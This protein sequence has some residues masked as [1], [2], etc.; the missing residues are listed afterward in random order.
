[1]KENNILN[2][3]EVRSLIQQ[4]KREELEYIIAEMYKMIPKEKKTDG[5]L[6]ELIKSP[7]KAKTDR[8]KSKAKAK[9]QRPFEEVLAE[10][11]FFVDNA[12]AQNYLVPN[13]TISKKERPKWRF[14]VKR[15]YKELNEYTADE[16]YI[17][18][19]ADALKELYEVMTYSCGYYLF[20]AYEPF[21]SIG[22]SQPDFY[23]S[24]INAFHT[25]LPKDSF[26]SRSI[27]LMFDNQLNRWTL[28]STL[29]VSF[30]EFIIIPDLYYKTIK[31]ADH[32][33]TSILEKHPSKKNMEYEIRNKINNYTELI[34]RCYFGLF[35]YDNALSDYK[36]YHIESDEEVKL[37]VLISLLMEFQA[38][39]IILKKLTDQEKKIKLRP[40][41]IEIK[42]YILEHNK[43]PDYL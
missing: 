39:E 34:F 32:K 5:N 28:Y 36:R 1:M 20:N 42:N 33:R 13:R 23:F 12:Y 19:A 15:L 8:K 40:R 17:K 3:S 18:E 27:D 26:I 24:V 21:D 29:M 14:V 9:K 11:E 41:L 31:I 25:F 7:A 43:L 35:E 4:H 22:I 30:L 16:K 2:I 6:S 38:K 10:V 37:Y